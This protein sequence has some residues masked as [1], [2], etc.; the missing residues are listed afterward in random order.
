[1]KLPNE[2]SVFLPLRRG[3]QGRTVRLV[4]EWLYL[5]DHG[6]TVDGTYGVATEATVRR[7]QT[8]QKLQPSGIVD[9][10]TMQAL[11]QP[12]VMAT[13]SL[14][15]TAET[16]PQ[17]VIAAARQ[18]LHQRPRAIGGGQYGPW[19]RLYTGGDQGPDVQWHA[20]FVSY[21]LDQAAEGAPAP[22]LRPAPA[23]TVMAL[24]TDAIRKDLFIPGRL[25]AED[26]LVRSQLRPGFLFLRRHPRRDDAWTHCGVVT[27]GMPEYIETIEAAV[28]DGTPPVGTDV[29]R[30]FRSYDTVDFI[31]L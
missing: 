28:H 18:H 10:A 6:T 20:S 15:T 12:I 7:F 3:M 5:H 25:V 27:A 26:P 19:I 22:P 14:T 30:R 4:Q 13:F 21:L 24:A 8:S 23:H 2:Y 31:R 9:E 1:M 17:R 29:A 11:V 16:Y